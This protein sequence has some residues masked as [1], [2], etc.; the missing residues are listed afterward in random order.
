MQDALYKSVRPMMAVSDGD[1]WLMSTPWGKRGFFYEEWTNGGDDWIRVS[2]P[3]TECPRIR[4]EFLE[5]ERRTMGER[6]FRQEYLCDFSD[7][8]DSVFRTDDIHAAI[9]HS[10]ELLRVPPFGGAKCY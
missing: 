2:A 1:L 3:A 8:D 4:P 7:T 6:W 5:G 10:I 9:D